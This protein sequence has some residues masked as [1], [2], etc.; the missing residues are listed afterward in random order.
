MRH[1][2]ATIA[3]QYKNWTIR[4]LLKHIKSSMEVKFEERESGE[5]ILQRGGQL[6]AWRNGKQ[7]CQGSGRKTP[8]SGWTLES[9]TSGVMV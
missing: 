7:I 6:E 2:L 3:P 5:G 8:I 9:E 4:I 1:P